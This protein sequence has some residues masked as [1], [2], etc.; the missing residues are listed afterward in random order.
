MA[1]RPAGGEADARSCLGEV[2][3]DVASL[4]PGAAAG[5]RPFDDAVALRFRVA[6]SGE[7][8]LGSPPTVPDVPSPGGRVERP[9]CQG[10]DVAGA[11]E[12]VASEILFRGARAT[13]CLVHE[14]WEGLPRRRA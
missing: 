8:D 6:P 4:T 11:V 5:P 14:A 13:A 2:T 7:T 12:A 3:A 10:G 9:S 1:L